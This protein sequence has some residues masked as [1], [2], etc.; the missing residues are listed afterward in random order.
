MREKEEGVLGT[1]IVFLLVLLLLAYSP[2]YKHARLVNASR[3]D[4]IARTR[5]PDLALKPLSMIWTERGL[6]SLIQ[7][8]LIL[9]VIAAIALLFKEWSR[10]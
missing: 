1:V 3:A 6:D 10:L 2:S 4:I 5:I 7:A 8:I 9:S